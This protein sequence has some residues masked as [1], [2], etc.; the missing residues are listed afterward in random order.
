MGAHS[1]SGGD[2]WLFTW[3]IIVGFP[4]TE[5]DINFDTSREKD[6]NAKVKSYLRRVFVR[7]DLL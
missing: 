5:G 3:R 1:T 2:I 7:S 6:H 4:Y